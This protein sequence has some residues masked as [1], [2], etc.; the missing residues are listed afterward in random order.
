[1]Y[2][3]RERCVR[4]VRSKDARF[5]GWFFTAVLT[6]GIYC[7]PSCPV[8]PPKPAN[9]VFHPSAAACQQAGFRACKRCRPDTTPGSPEWNQRA[10]LVARAMRLIADGVVDR[11]GV[12]GLAARLGYSTR[13]IERQLLAELGAGPLALARAQRAQTARLLIE[14]TRLPMADVT[15][16]AGFASIR[17]FNDTVRDVFALSPSELRARVPQQNAPATPGILQ[18]RLPFRAPLNPDN[19]FGHLAATG[20]PGVEEWRDGAFRRT[21]RLPYGHGI[22]A[23]T[24]NPDHIGCRLTLSD[25]RDLTVASSRCRRMLDLDADPVAVDDQLRTDPLLAP[26]VD[27]APGR[28]VPRTVDEAEFAVRAVLGQQVST[29]AARTHAA[30]LVTA[31]GDPID[32]PEGGLTHLF[33]TPEALAAVD[34]EHLAMP[35]TRRTTFTTLVGQL[36]DGT[37]NLGVDSDWAEARARL[38]ALPGFGPWTVDVIAMRALGDPDAFLPTDL[39]IRRAAQQSGLP[40]TPAA[41]TARAAAWRPWRAYAVQYLWATDSHPINFL[42]A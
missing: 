28:R 40:S 33:P 24:P 18:L 21:L 6:T 23:L 35:R 30:R 14:T 19:L 16:A 32:D 13:Q 12:P 34:P 39:G 36:A 38:L 15:F 27:K 41:L 3:D 2:T 7:R 10:D 26:L 22:V 8:V 25:L 37:L 20:V 42:P 11:D 29:A 4:A 5:D 9:M 17:T 1:M 31:Y